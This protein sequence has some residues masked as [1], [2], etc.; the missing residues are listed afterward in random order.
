[1]IAL[2]LV[3]VAICLTV[4]FAPIYLQ[5]KK[6]SEVAEKKWEQEDLTVYVRY[7]HFD[8]PMLQSQVVRWEKMTPD[9]KWWLLCQLKE[10]VKAKKLTTEVTDGITKFVGITEKG[11]DIKHRQKERTDG[12]KQ[13]QEKS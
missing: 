12:W 2:T 3:V 4:L 9:E 10:Q 13:S 1:M 8:I 6:V 5:R 11:K 7:G